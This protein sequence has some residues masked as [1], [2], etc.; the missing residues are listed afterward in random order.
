ML[1]WIPKSFWGSIKPHNGSPVVDGDT[2]FVSDTVCPGPFATEDAREVIGGLL[3]QKRTFEVHAAV[4]PG[5]ADASLKFPSPLPQGNAS[6]DNVILDWYM[7]RDRFGEAVEAPAVLVLDILQG[8][9]LVS[10]CI[11]RSFAKSGVHA[12]VMH[13]AQNGRRRNPEED[14]DWSAF[15]P[16]LRQGV[17]DARRSR[18]VV[19]AMPLVKGPIALQGTSLGGFVATI[20]ASIDDAF[21][22]VLLALTGGDVFGV[23]TRGR[24]DAARVRRQLGE[25]GFTDDKLRQW[26]WQIEPMRVAHRL[27]PQKTW[28]F[29]ARFDQVVSAAHS[30]SLAAEIGLNWHHH[31][32][33]AGCHYSCV[34]SAPRFLKELARAVPRPAVKPVTARPR[35]ASPVHDF[36]PDTGLQISLA[37]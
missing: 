24:A 1:Q 6:W 9:N 28:L 35:E 19:A 29:S 2:Y 15:L 18:D 32:Q 27:N 36:I 23:L 8:G 13:L 22:P 3:W 33:F 11:A 26:L 31:R 34:F 25:I 12:F 30:K 21:S 7:A 4:E 5:D 17:A 10:G 37:H 16:A 20:T 14:H